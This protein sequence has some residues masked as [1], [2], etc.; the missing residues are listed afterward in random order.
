[1]GRKR[2]WRDEP[3][4]RGIRVVLAGQVVWFTDQWRDWRGPG[5]AAPRHLVFA[6]ARY[7]ESLLI[8]GMPREE[9]EWATLEWLRE[10]LEA[11]RGF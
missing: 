2:P 4:G 7:M 1:M 8:L 9:A 6:A 10:T 11:L 5:I 3:P